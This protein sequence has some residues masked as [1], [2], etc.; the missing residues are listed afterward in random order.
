MASFE[1][2]RFKLTNTQINKSKS[3]AKNNTGT[4]L[5]ITKKN[6]QDEGLPYELFI[7]TRQKAKARNAFANNMSTDIKFSKSQLSKII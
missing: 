5:R 1:E 7:T 6:C 3:T 4:T 2:A